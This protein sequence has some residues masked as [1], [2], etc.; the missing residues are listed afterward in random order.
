MKLD[1][2]KIQSADYG[3][4]DP[5]SF[6]LEHSSVK[7]LLVLLDVRS[8][9]RGAW[10][11]NGDPPT[12]AEWDTIQEFVSNT[13]EELFSMGILAIEGG[14]TGAD[15]AADA[16]D[17]LGLAPGGEGDIWVEKAG[18]IMT[19]ELKVDTVIRIASPA[20]GV[21]AIGDDALQGVTGV[22]N[23]GVGY[24]VGYSLIGGI[25]NVFLGS[26]AGYKALGSNNVFLG[27]NAGY[28]NAS[29]DNNVFLGH[30]AG[31]YETG[32]HKLYIATSSTTTPLIYG[33]FDNALIEFSATKMGFFDASA[34][35]KPPALT[36]TKTQI[37]HTGPTTPDYAIATPIDSD[38]AS[39]WGFST[40]DE[41][42]TIMSVVQNLQVR[43]DEL[44]AK[45]QGLGLLA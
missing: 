42:E 7:L 26:L 36:A 14:G 44:E 38:V 28:E 18:D 19:G 4:V 8:L 37:T 35:V 32:S 41:F 30:Y 9:F 10:T 21:L 33:E 20:T 15:N 27:V 39:A 40:R 43:V 2:G 29:G 22:F 25:F 13:I 1:W 23:T 11:V 17:N 45:L 31:F 12:D 24:N 5:S 16:R 34:I 3:S 6:I